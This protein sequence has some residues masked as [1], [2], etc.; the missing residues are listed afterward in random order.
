METIVEVVI[1]T[2][3]IV[4]AAAEVGTRKRAGIR[5]KVGTKRRVGIR[6]TTRV[7]GKRKA[8]AKIRREVG[9]KARIEDRTAEEASQRETVGVTPVTTAGPG[10]ED[11]EVRDHKQP[12]FR[13]HRP[14]MKGNSTRISTVVILTQPP[15]MVR[16]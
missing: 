10:E 12:R 7:H 5:R 4:T 3:R 16:T 13:R 15:S 14:T 11:L 2:R 6:A 8:G 1:G 9:T